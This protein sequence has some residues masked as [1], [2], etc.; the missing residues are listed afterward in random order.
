A[1]PTSGAP[2][3]CCSRPDTSL[4]AARTARSD[5]SRRSGWPGRART[6]AASCRS[7]RRRPA[8]ISSLLPP[9]CARRVRR[10]SSPA[11]TAA[12]RAPRGERERP[13]DERRARHLAARALAGAAPPHLRRLLAQ[14]GVRDRL[15]R[16]VERRDLP[17][18][19][20][21]AL[22]VLGPPVQLRELVADPVEPLE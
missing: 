11:T 18:Q 21:E 20:N 17:D 13:R 15:Q 8:P 3:R 1:T 19:A 12:R 14:G 2:P 9:S 10:G 4:R 22:V 16:F 5:C 7:S 6:A